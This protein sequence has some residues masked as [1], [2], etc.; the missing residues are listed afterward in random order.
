MRLEQLH[1]IIEI[2]KQQSISKAAKALYMGQPALSN[3][4]NGLEE[5]IGVRLFERNASGILPTEEGK[6]VLELAKQAVNCTNQI[7][8]IGKQDSELYGDVTL[9]T[10]Q[11]YTSIYSDIVVEFRKRY[12]KAELKLM[13]TTPDKILEAM[14]NGS[15]NIALTTWGFFP[16]ETPE[17]LKK[18]GLHAET[19]ATHSM[20][21][22]V[23]AQHRLAGRDH[24]SLEELRDEK[25]ISYSPAH[26]NVLNQTLQANTQP[27]IVSSREVFAHLIQD[28]KAVAILPD[29]DWSHEQGMVNVI[30]INEYMALGQN[31]DHILYPAKRQLNLLEKRTIELL[32]EIMKE[33]VKR[34]KS[35]YERK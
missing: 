4:L 3:S 27:L 23:G 14:Q 29:T 16:D 34:N 28:K 2:E 25:F 15:A 21:L 6:K 32:R 22:Y 9:L 12:P 11:A 17:A 5:E 30:P 13:I 35:K 19:F 10:I 33:Y 18:A 24:V 7:I 26:W 20:A 31:V 1:Q 8:N